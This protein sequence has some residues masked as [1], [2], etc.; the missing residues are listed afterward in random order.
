MSCGRDALNRLISTIRAG[1]KGVFPT[2][3]SYVVAGT[4]DA[5]FTIFSN[6][7]RALAM[8]SNEPIATALAERFWPGPLALK[9]RRRGGFLTMT[10]TSDM[11]ARELAEG[12]GGQVVTNLLNAPTLDEAMKRSGPVDVAVDC[13]P[14]PFPE[15][16]TIIK[17][18]G[19]TLRAIFKGAIP[20]EMV[21]RAAE[22]AVI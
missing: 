20:I 12:L 18:E 21:E 16:Y 11:R 10:V 7:E 9:V 19:Y 14:V 5:D 1:G 17:V 2:E 6:K 15:G 22:E 13:G 8:I 3:A 4:K